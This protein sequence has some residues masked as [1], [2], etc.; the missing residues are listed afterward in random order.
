MATALRVT[1]TGALTSGAYV[2]EGEFG[3]RTA[4]LLAS[5]DPAGRLFSWADLDD[6]FKSAPSVVVAAFW[7]PRW[8]LSCWGTMCCTRT[9]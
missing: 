4:S 6:A 7:R 8:T 3:L 2:G 9:A 5:R 1:A